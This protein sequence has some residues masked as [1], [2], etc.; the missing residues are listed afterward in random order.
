[1]TAR[2]EIDHGRR[3]GAE[4]WKAEQEILANRQDQ[5]FKSLAEYIE[6]GKVRG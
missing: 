6:H 4:A 5:R 1:L 2:A 3:I